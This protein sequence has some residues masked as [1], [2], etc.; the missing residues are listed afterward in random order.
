MDTEEFAEG[1]QELLGM[2]FGVRTAVMCAE[3]LWWRCHRRLIADVVQGL[4]FRVQH[5]MSGSV[6]KDH[7]A[8]RFAQVGEGAPESDHLECRVKSIP[9]L[10]CGSPT[11]KSSTT[12]MVSE[13]AKVYSACGGLAKVKTQTLSWAWP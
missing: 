12:S 4:G 13:F 2:A 5:I 3:A 1:L 7:T 8:T 11:R 6:V 10:S 9:T